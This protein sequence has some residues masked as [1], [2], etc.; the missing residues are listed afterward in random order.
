VIQQAIAKD[1][2]LVWLNYNTSYA[3]SN[4]RVQNLNTIYSSITK[5]Y[6]VWV[7]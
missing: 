2:P 3:I 6:Q 4:T 7:S 5:P 1:V